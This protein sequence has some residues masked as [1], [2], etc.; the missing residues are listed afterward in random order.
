MRAKRRPA[1]LWAACMFALL[2]PVYIRCSTPGEPPTPPGPRSGELVEAGRREP[3][4]E[5]RALV[6]EHAEFDHRAE[7]AEGGSTAERTYHEAAGQALG[8]LREAARAAAGPCV[9]GAAPAEVARLDALAASLGDE[10]DRHLASAGGGE[11]GPDGD[12][13][14]HAAKA[15]DLLDELDHAYDDVERGARRRA[16]VGCLWHGDV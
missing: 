15:L 11:G 2:P 4:G 14:P 7:G 16:S 10:L 9:G 13:R 6:T 8:R 1:G 12:E 5:L 3:L